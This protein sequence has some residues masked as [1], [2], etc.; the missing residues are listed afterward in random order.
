VWAQA[1]LDNLFA[2]RWPRVRGFSWW[3][4]YWQNDDNPAHDTTMR[5]QDI[6]A[7]AAVF[8]DTLAAHQAQL[9]TRPVYAP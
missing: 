1:A 7:L 6:P 2:N 8:H 3:N 5:V 4:E 9:Q